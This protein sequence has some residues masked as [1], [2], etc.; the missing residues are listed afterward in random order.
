MYTDDMYRASNE[1][2]RAVEDAIT[3]GLTV[4]QFI[5]VARDCWRERLQDMQRWA[6]KD[7]QH[8]LMKEGR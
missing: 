4:Q 2:S 6:D 7:F 1:I 5:E 3:R 8:A